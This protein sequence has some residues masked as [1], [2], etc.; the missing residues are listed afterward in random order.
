MEQQVDLLSGRRVA[1]PSP[2]RKE[3]GVDSSLQFVPRAGQDRQT[4]L[5]AA[6]GQVMVTVTLSLRAGDQLPVQRM[7]PPPSNLQAAG[8]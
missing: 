4:N 3:P 5:Q 1:V 6:L 8:Q 7:Y 2:T